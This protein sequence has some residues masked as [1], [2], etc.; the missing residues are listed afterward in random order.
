MPIYAPQVDELIDPS[1]DTEDNF[2]QDRHF[3]FRLRS[4]FLRITKLVLYR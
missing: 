4:A 2:Y 1:N 3:Y